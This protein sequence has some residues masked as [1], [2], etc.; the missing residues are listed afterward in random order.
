MNNVNG[1]RLQA[2]V[3]CGLLACSAFAQSPTTEPRR[4]EVPVPSSRAFN[5]GT[6]REFNCIA[7]TASKEQVSDFINSLAKIENNEAGQFVIELSEKHNS[8]EG[9]S[10]VVDRQIIVYEQTSSDP[11]NKNLIILAPEKLKLAISF[12]YTVPVADRRV[13]TKSSVVIGSLR[14][15][16]Q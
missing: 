5:E 8:T 13:C 2:G 12:A 15:N 6:Y 7:T 11:N 1:F 10:F 14:K 9:R 4:S 16:T 3:L